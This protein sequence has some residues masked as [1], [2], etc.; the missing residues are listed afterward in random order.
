MYGHG[1]A[2]PGSH[3]NAWTASPDDRDKDNLLIAI[4]AL[5]CVVHSHLGV[6]LKVLQCLAVAVGPSFIWSHRQHM[7]EHHLTAS[8][9]L[10]RARHE[11][12]EFGEERRVEIKKRVQEFNEGKKLD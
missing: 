8:A 11:A 6:V 10:A 5:V 9:N 1:Y 3:E 12:R 2:Y 7:E 4:G